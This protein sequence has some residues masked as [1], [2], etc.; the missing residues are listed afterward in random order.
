MSVSIKAD[1]KEADIFVDG[2]KVGRIF[3]GKFEG[4]DCR[5]RIGTSFDRIADGMG[6]AERIAD[7]AAEIRFNQAKRL[8]KDFAKM[9]AAEQEAAKAAKAT[10]KVEAPA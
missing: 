5:V 8:E 10:P 6:E 9:I 4:G 2:Y 1:G 3:R 7:R